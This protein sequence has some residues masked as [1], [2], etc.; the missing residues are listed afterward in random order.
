M[1]RRRWDRPDE[2]D[3]VLLLVD[4]DDAHREA[5]VPHLAAIAGRRRRDVLGRYPRFRV[6]E[7]VDGDEAMQRATPDVTV[8]AVDLVLPKIPGLKIVQQL[9]DARPDLAVLAFATV[10]PPSEAVASVMAGADHFFEW[11]TDS[12]PTELERAVELAIDR[13]RLT[14]TIEQQEAEVEQARGRLAALRGPGA[15]GF[16]GAPPTRADVLPFREAARRYLAAAAR[17]HEGDPH[18]LAK[19]L[20]VSYFGLRRLLARHDVPF[21]GKP[22]GRTPRR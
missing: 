17:L 12:E 22:R 2:H 10:A 8:V 4:P 3:H 6:I 9:R 20:G 14:R 1:A 21:P 15:A 16:A 18:G 7:A 19:K 5:V 11:R 13:R